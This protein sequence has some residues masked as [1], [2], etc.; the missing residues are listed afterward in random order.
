MDF[1]ALQ[2]FKSKYNFTP[3][4]ILDI[5]A[6]NGYFSDMCRDIWGIYVDMTLIEANPSLE[7]TLKNKGYEYIISLLGNETKP[8]VDFFRTKS[9]SNSTGC[10]IYKELSPF[11]NDQNV[12]TIQLP[13]NRL[14]DI[15]INTF[16]FIKMDTQGSELDIIK[17]GEKTIDKCKYL[18]IEVSLIPLNKDAPLK[19]DIVNHLQSIGFKQI[20][21]LYS[22]YNEGTLIQEDLLFSK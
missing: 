4:H 22:H 10:S 12:D 8:S 19:S 17:G 15:T 11:F 7:Q 16:D 6:S 9:D 18:L 20:D 21:V 2:T 1:K 5:G 3:R 14:D 13:M